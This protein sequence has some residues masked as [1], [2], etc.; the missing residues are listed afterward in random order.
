MKLLS[1]AFALIILVPVPAFSQVISFGLGGDITFPSAELKDN[2]STGYGAT[3]LARF[4]LLPIL[5]LTGGLEYIKFT[6]KSITVNNLPAEGTGSAFGILVGGRVNF[7]V[8]GYVGAETG[9]YSFMKKVAGDEEKIT[10]GVFAPMAGVKLGMFDFCARYV[11]AGDDTFWG[12]RGLI[13][14]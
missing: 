11:S 8:V 5:D 12:L 10:R 6:D 3:A 9:T 2:V 1:L 14:F 13:W 4:G 7:L